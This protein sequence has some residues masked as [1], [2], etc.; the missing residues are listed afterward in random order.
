[1]YNTV[2]IYHNGDVSIYAESD[3]KSIFVVFV[4]M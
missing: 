2:H 1:M 4:H 3:H